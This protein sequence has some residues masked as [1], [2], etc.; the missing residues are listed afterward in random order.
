VD[1]HGL[2]NEQHQ[3]YR[4]GARLEDVL[5]NVRNLVQAKQER[6]RAYP[7]VFMDV[8]ISR[9]NEQDYD[10]FVQ[11]AR[12][13]KV[14]GVILSAIRDDVFHTQ[15]WQPRSPRFAEKKRQGEYRCHFQDTLVGILSW[16]GDIQLCCMTPNFPEHVSRGNAFRADDVLALLDSPG[17]LET[18]KQCGHY[19]FCE[20]CFLKNAVGYNKTINF[21]LPLGYIL[22]KLKA[23]PWRIARKF[24]HRGF[25]L[26]PLAVDK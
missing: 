7:L 17:F 20:L 13:L 26:G 18:T 25:G 6:A 19:P 21:R 4:V 15:T 5:Q 1:V 3:L 22:R 24:F 14:N 8:L 23:D 2:S 9:H 11:L 16:D 12:D 10:A